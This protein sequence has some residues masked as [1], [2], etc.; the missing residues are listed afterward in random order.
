MSTTAT[1]TALFRAYDASLDVQ[2]GERSVVAT[3][4]SDAVDSF[5]SVIL[6]AGA[7]LDHY[8]SNPVVLLNH[9]EER[10]VGRNAWITSKGGRLRAKTVFMGPDLSD[11]AD[12]TFRKYQQGF[13]RGFS[14][15]F[16]PLKASAPTRDEVRANPAWSG[17]ETVYREWELLEYSAVAL[18][19]NPEALA[20]AVSRG[21]ARPE[22]AEKAATDPLAG[23]PKLVGRTP[24]QVL[25]A[26]WRHAEG[27]LRDQAGRV[28]GD[29]LDLAR[30]KV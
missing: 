6:P 15:R 9:D 14:I 1:A 20:E 22:W 10:V 17:V 28:L 18:P 29:A 3:I 11:E 13:M 30:G 12:R 2:E 7:K 16:E 21:M 8:R 26:L 23:L 4:N 25:D 5:R 19:A 24:Q 27:R